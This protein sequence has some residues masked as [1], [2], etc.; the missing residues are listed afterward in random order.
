[1]IGS[2]NINGGTTYDHAID[3]IAAIVALRDKLVLELGL[4]YI[5]H[6]HVDSVIGWIW[7]FFNDYDWKKN[8]LTIEQ[9]TLIAIKKQYMKIQKVRLADSWGVDFHKSI[10]GCPVN[11]S[12]F[13]INNFE[14]AMY[15]SRKKDGNIDTHQLAQEYSFASPVDYTLETSRSAGAPLAA[16]TALFTQGKEG[17]Q[18]NLANLIQQSEYI[19]TELKYDENIV[20]ANNSSSSFVTMLRVIPPDLKHVPFKDE[21]TNSDSSTK[22]VSDKITKYTKDFF[23]WDYK[24]RIKKGIGPEYSYSSSYTTTSSGAKLGAI[25]LYPVSPFFSRKYATET[26]KTVKKQ[27][28]TYGLIY[29]KEN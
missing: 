10:G 12:L 9:N 8:P 24:T 27:I 18:I 21:L 4:T 1:M 5:P 14:D 20:I 25:K 16:L 7:L 22:S 26:V 15:L 17:Y 2:I 13:M 28:K 11:C 19:R 29:G 6:V 23:E 3:D